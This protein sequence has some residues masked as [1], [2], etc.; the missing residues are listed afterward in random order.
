MELRWERK[1]KEQEDRITKQINA[2]LN[3][4]QSKEA[5]LKAREKRLQALADELEKK[6][7]DLLEP[8]TG[9]E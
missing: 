2:M 5:D 9:N 6:Y 4:Q 7:M 8:A 3:T 1:F